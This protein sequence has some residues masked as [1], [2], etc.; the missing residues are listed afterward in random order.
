[1]ETSFKFTMPLKVDVIEE[2]GEQK[3]FLE[4]FLST[5]D[6]DLVNDIVTKNCLESMQRQILERNIKLDIEHEAF[7]GKSFEEKEI[8]KTRIPAGRFIDAAV[9]KIGN[10]RWGL[11]V[12]AMLNRFN[13]RY[14]EIK[15]NVMDRMLDAYSIAFIATKVRHE[16]INGKSMRFLDDLALLNSALTGNPINTEAINREVFFKSINSLEDYEAEKK[17]NPDTE[18]LLEVKAGHSAKWHRLVDELRKRGEVDSPEAVATE[19]LGDE[20]FKS[21]S[22]SDEHDNQL[23][24]RRLSNMTIETHDKE[25]KEEGVH[26]GTYGKEGGNAPGKE[27]VDETTST[28][29]VSA[30]APAK[31]DETTSTTTTEMKSA[32]SHL[33]SRVDALEAENKQLKAIS[34]PKSPGAN[35]GTMKQM[36]FEQKSQKKFSGPLDFI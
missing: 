24:K 34:V 33:T 10:N 2:K 7:R 15:G 17:A 31:E 26:G 5:S 25:M 18:K 35:A 12:K 3:V 13:P 6:P 21:Y 29:T 27:K 19:Q 23:T 32:I 20:S 11:R 36:E 4:G 9:E 8:N 30:K 16:T 22:R 14:N 28:G 1:M